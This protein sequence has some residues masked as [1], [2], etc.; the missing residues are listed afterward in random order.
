MDHHVKYGQYI[1]SPLYFKDIV[2]AFK[3]QIQIVNLL[4]QIVSNPTTP[5]WS[6]T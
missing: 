2:V 4:N 5:V 6:Y 3:I 1:Q